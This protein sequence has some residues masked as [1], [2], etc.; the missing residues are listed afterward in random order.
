MRSKNR[1]VCG[2]G[3]NDADY[4]VYLCEKVDGKS[5]I[6]WACPYY[7]TWTS[8]LERCYSDKYHKR[9]PTYI[10]CT[11]C[12]EW[13]TFSNFRNWMVKQ[14]WENNQLDK[15]LLDIGNKVYGPDSCVFVTQIVNSFLTASG[16]A[17]GE[18]PIGAYF[19]KQKN[20]FNAQCCNPFTGKREYLGYFNDPDQAHL[21]W[22][23]RKH[24]LACQLA[25]SE[26]VTDDRVAKALR[27]RYL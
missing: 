15:D 11:V 14:D 20:K 5:K 7:R 25:D 16:N 19:N 24:E 26:Y 6:L 23:K 12:E 4:N 17:R 27:T 8:M 18:Y 22:K 13:L 10:G 3:V 1:L 9:R 2:V 21:A